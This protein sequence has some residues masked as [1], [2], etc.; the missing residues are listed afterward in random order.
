MSFSHGGHTR[1]LAQ[2]AGLHAEDILDLSASI[3]PLGPPES[4]R[5]VIS[6]TLDGVTSYPDPECAELV[7]TLSAAFGVSSEKVIVGNGSTEILHALLRAVRRDRAVIPVPSYTD[8]AD[9]ARLVGMRVETVPLREADGF[10]L[11]WDR[12]GRNLHG[13][14]DLHGGD[15]VFLGRPNNPTGVTFEADVFRRFAAEHAETLF[16]VDEAFADFV[17]GLESLAVDIAENV[18]VLRSLTKFYAIPGLRLGAAVARGDLAARIR[19]QIPPWSVNTLAQAAGVAAL[20]DSEYARRSREFV[21]REREKLTGAMSEI[22]GLHVYPGSANF[23]LV[24]LES[25]SINAGQLADQLLCK[26]IA[27]RVCESFEGLDGWFFR[28]AVGCEEDNTRLVEALE[29]ALHKTQPAPTS[30][31][32]HVTRKRA[33]SLMFQGTSS[34]AGKSVLAAALCR[35]LLQDGLRVAPFKSQ[36]MSLNSFV[37][38]EGGEMGRAQV[39]QAQASRLEP[40][41]S[42]NPV[43]LKPTSDT[44]CQ[45]I[46]CGHSVGNMDVQ[47]YIRYKPQA[48]DAARQCYDRLAEQFDAVVLEGAGSPAEINLKQHDIV[49]MEMARYAGATVLL[50]GDIDRGG[51]FASFVGTMEL[52]SPWERRLI[53]GLVINRFRG[54]ASLLGPAIEHTLRHTGK[55]TLAV[56]PYVHD[57]G[58]PE[59]DSV[60]FKSAPCEEAS[61]DGRNVDI[62]V[63][64][65]PHISNFTDF[66]ALRVESDVVVR[67]VRSADEL[68]TPDAAIIPGSKNVLSDLE[69]LKQRGMA[70]GLKKLAAKGTTQLIGICGGFQML[71]RSIAD[72]LSVES[73]G[74]TVEGLGLLNVNTALAAQKTL[75]RS[76]AMHIPSGC[77]VAG[78]EIHH[79][80]TETDGEEALF[81]ADSQTDNG[82]ALGVASRRVDVWGTYLHGVFDADPFRRWFVDRLRVRKGLDPLGEVSASYDVEPALN[83]LARI[84]R[85]NIDLNEIY[86][87][88][89][90]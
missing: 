5:R 80:Q 10:A 88:M 1:R 76:Q 41:V 28:V 49:N 19:R 71:G 44:G 30:T 56:V 25:E 59:E 27:I 20:E 73:P 22:P 2:R 79:G 86:R 51:V 69:Y 50:V 74:G 84:V 12:L 54:D 24:R 34:N 60:G 7:D 87:Q 58:L 40:D 83:R 3:N 48:F 17:E 11:D 65:L 9:A 75:A 78:Y 6:R 33:A 38:V 64:D 26:A 62:A 90:L 72:P 21:A 47:Q 18:A 63:I 16:V 70:A 8:Y 39:V 23:L 35:I 55:P 52:L 4:L 77:R 67:T 43:L 66:D 15:V 32:K 85:D 45:V 42:M 31:K 13:S 82:P 57:L 68:G 46:V 29:E 36:N 53:G 89:G 81:E 14:D 37:T 61:G